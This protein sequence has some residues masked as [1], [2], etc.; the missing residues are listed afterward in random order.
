KEKAIGSELGNFF[1]GVDK[2]DAKL[3]KAQ[4]AMKAGANGNNAGNAAATSPASAAADMSD[5][6]RRIGGYS[7][8]T[9]AQ[10]DRA[11]MMAKKQVDILSQVDSKLAVLENAARTGGMIFP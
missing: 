8:A 3:K 7:G 11:A 9:P 4:E 5:T 2:A 1:G 10:G 6:L